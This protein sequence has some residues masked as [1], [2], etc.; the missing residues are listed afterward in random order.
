MK[1]LVYCKNTQSNR[2]ALDTAVEMA[3]AFGAEVKLI[4]CIS[5]QTNMPTEVI[6][7]AQASLQEH[8]EEY[9]GPK[10]INCTAQV[11]STTIGFGEE[12]VKLADREGT[13]AIIMG[14]QKRSKVGKIFFGSVTQ[15]I[16]LEAPCKVITVK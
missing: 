13:D 7:Q 5:E 12:I 1:I 3:Q 8:I 15:Y 6:E 2:K 11:V 4:K 14:I 10:K 16:I 9:F